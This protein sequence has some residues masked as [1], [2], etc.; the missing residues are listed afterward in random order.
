MLTFQDH[1]SKYPEA[2][3]LPDQKVTAITRVFIEEI[4]CWHGT[5]KRVLANQGANFT[6]ELFQEICKLQDTEKLQTTAYH[7]ESNGII[8][9]SHHTIMT[10]LMYW[11][12]SKELGWMAIIY[13]DGLQINAIQYHKTF[14]LLFTSPERDVVTNQLDKGRS[15][16]RLKWRW[17]STRDQMLNADSQSRGNECDTAMER[18]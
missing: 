3:D 5:P 17:F 11:W 1:F 8:E 14:P 9:R 18:I 10:G 6:S 15:T 13:H 16:A 4:I 7:T 2:F 12:R